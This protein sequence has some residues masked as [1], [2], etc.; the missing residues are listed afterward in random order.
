MAVDVHR[1]RNE[2]FDSFMRRF[3]RKVQMSGRQVQAKKI[4]F[5]ER[6]QSKASQ[7]HVALQRAQ[8]RGYFSYL[9]KIGKLDEELAKLRTR[10]RS[11][12]R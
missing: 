7:R 8:K 9:E 12:R 3:T 2:S 11:R 4:R 10:K 1:R 6:N 5:Y